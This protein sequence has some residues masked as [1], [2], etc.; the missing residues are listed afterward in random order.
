[1]KSHQALLKIPGK[2]RHLLYFAPTIHFF[3]LSLL[4]TFCSLFIPSFIFFF[5]SL[6]AQV[7][8]NSKSACPWSSGVSRCSVPRFH[9]TWESRDAMFPRQPSSRQCLPTRGRRRQHVD[10]FR[11]FTTVKP[12]PPIIDFGSFTFVESWFRPSE[13]AERRYVQKEQFI[14][15]R[16]TAD[17]RK[18][19]IAQIQVLPNKCSLFI[20]VKF[21]Q[22]SL[23]REVKQVG[24]STLTK[25]REIE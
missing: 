4:P 19:V 21:I 6:R 8:G 20:A 11:T 7:S 23:L 10:H 12:E 18:Y 1:M 14:S 15:R 16:E 5:Q 24:K 2:S 22:I 3:F 9:V 13:V 17:R 25:T